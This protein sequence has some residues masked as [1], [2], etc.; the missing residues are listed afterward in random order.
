MLFNTHSPRSLRWGKALQVSGLALFACLSSHAF[1]A[2]MA[3]ERLTFTEGKRVVNQRVMDTFFRRNPEVAHLSEFFL[4]PGQKIT[5][6]IDIGDDPNARLQ[7]VAKRGA[8]DE[9]LALV[10]RNDDNV[11]VAD[12][13]P[14][15]IDGELIIPANRNLVD[16]TDHLALLDAGTDD[17]EN[18]EV[19]L[20]DPFFDRF[21]SFA[22]RRSA[23]IWVSRIPGNDQQLNL[24]IL[25]PKQA[26]NEVYETVYGVSGD[27]NLLF[28][29]GHPASDG[30]SAAA[31]T[32]N[33]DE[34]REE[35]LQTLAANGVETGVVGG[36]YTMT[37]AVDGNAISVFDRFIDGRLAYRGDTEAAG[38]GY[39]LE[40]TNFNPLD[41]Q[42]ALVRSEFGQFVLGLSAGSDEVFVMRV[43]RDTNELS[44]ADS[45]PSGGVFPQ[46]VAI[47]DDLVY[48]LN[49]RNGASISGFKI[50]PEGQLTPIAD[51]TRSL[52]SGGDNPVSNALERDVLWH[53]IA[54]TPEGDK[55]VVVE[56]G[57]NSDVIHVFGIHEDGTATERVTSVSD[58]E[59]PLAVSF[60]D[61]DVLLVTESAED[62]SVNA[63]TSYRIHDDLSLSII[64]GAVLNFQEASCWLV[65]HKD[66][67]FTVNSVSNNFSSYRVDDQGQVT[68]IDEVAG[69]LLQGPPPVFDDG[70]LDVDT[71]EQT[72]RD[73]TAP[74]FPTDAAVSVGGRFLYSLNLGNSTISGFALDAS[75]AMNFLS[76]FEGNIV[77]F[78]G[79]QGMAAR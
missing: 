58:S 77:P 25:L 2:D 17:G 44:L 36:V 65:G 6:V 53:E 34:L 27:E 14:L 3:G 71:L 54:F 22:L 50:S 20:A 28:N 18:G 35:L 45:A 67:F 15:R 21:F 57:P 63:V 70:F 69:Q 64:T 16:L 47:H 55:L 39:E 38:L 42:G 40:G 61:N 51:S 41:S 8:G 48:V 75:G 72:L 79:G 37:N 24:S 78:G 7:L 9:F 4:A 11:I 10:E 73:G 12:S 49:G 32:G 76:D 66:T 26:R 68:I 52:G 56:S 43:N 33:S 5:K 1:A 60:T 46:S 23:R 31:T 30:L 74:P 62:E 19:N 29:I 59:N 13:I